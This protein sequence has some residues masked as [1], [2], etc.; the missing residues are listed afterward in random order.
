MNLL[1]SQP[2][3]NQTVSLGVANRNPQTP[4]DDYGADVNDTWEITSIDHIFWPGLSLDLDSLMRAH[5]GYK[6]SELH[7]KDA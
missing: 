6:G 7:L 4:L 3:T 1:L 5:L 2:S